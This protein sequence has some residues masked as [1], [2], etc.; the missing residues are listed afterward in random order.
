MKTARSVRLSS[1]S[2]TTLVN[3]TAQNGEVFY[4]QT[5]KTLRLFDGRTKGGFQLLRADLANAT[6]SFGI[7]IGANP[8]ADPQEGTQWIKSTTGVLYVYYVDTNGGHWIQPVTKPVGTMEVA[9]TLSLASLFST[10]AVQPDGTSI[11]IDGEGIISA[12]FGNISYVNSTFLG[13]TNT[14]LPST[15][16]NT[17]NGATGTVVH[18][19]AVAGSTFYHT[20][21]IDNFTANFTNMP[22]TNNRSTTVSLV[23]AQNNPAFIASSVQINGVTQTLNW[24]NGAVPQGTIGGVDVIQFTII[25]VNN[26]WT[27]SGSLSKHG[28]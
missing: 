10:G 12:I 3:S 8:P 28:V 27:V 11:T 4:D 7:S 20:N 18:D 16:L 5:N 9:P 26:A 14:Q 22:T 17:I 2:A 15:V 21:V 6:G 24:L 1:T 13:Y 25:R 23:I 19:I